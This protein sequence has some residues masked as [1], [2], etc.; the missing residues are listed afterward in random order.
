MIKVNKGER[1][2]NTNYKV[3]IPPVAFRQETEKRK[4]GKKKV[5]KQQ[6][7]EDEKA[8]LKEKSKE[9]DIKKCVS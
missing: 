2:R 9:I 4:L 6:T 7:E 1:Q 8:I 3:K 5:V